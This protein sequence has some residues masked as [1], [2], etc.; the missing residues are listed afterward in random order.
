[1][2][3]VLR[4][5][6][7]GKTQFIARLSGINRFEIIDST[8]IVSVIHLNQEKIRI[9]KSKSLR[10]SIKNHTFGKILNEQ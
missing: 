6:K 1:M 3:L 5:I 4:F 2:L 7:L 10:V 8:S 9:N